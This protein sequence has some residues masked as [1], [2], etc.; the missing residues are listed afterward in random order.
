[1][2]YNIKRTT[3]YIYVMIYTTKKYT[4]DI[5]K[6]TIMREELFLIFLYKKKYLVICYMDE[7]I[8]YGIT[9]FLKC[10]ICYDIINNYFTF[11]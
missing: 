1:M 7:D 4:Y 11:L 6:L 5:H 10:W 3:I 9:F 8:K 2:L